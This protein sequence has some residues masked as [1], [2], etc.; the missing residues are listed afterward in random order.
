LLKECLDSEKVKDVNDKKMLCAG[1]IVRQIAK[2][3]ETVKLK[4]CH[5]S[6]NPMSPIEEFSEMRK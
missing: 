6:Y 2:H 4:P 1:W 5:D 3:G